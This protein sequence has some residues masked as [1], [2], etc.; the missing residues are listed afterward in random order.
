MPSK[1]MFWLLQVTGEATYTDDI[2]LPSN[3]L[4]AALVY[5]DRP[6]AKIL[7]IDATDAF[8]VHHP[9]LFCNLS[10]LVI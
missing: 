4:R 5:S 10:L 6:H 2:P 7:S 3:A 8:E 1:L 9:L